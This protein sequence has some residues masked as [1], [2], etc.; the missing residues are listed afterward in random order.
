MQILI[1]G[2]VIIKM[3]MH[4]LKQGRRQQ[5][6]MTYKSCMASC[7]QVWI[8]TWVMMMQVL[9]FLLLFS[10]S[11]GTHR[12]KTWPL[13]TPHDPIFQCWAAPHSWSL[14]WKILWN[15][16]PPLDS[17]LR[18]PEEGSSPHTHNCAF[19]PDDNNSRKERKI[20]LFGLRCLFSFRKHR[21]E[22]IFLTI[23]TP[24]TGHMNSVGAVVCN[25]IASYVFLHPQRNILGIFYCSNLALQIFIT[26]SFCEC[27]ELGSI[28]VFT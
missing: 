13:H 26:F 17:R 4:I 22:N 23:L 12:W 7:I 10:C 28:I 24:K 19:H 1:T 5:H 14:W 27:N 15:L 25:M 2:L 16:V 3:Y 9:P 11:L 6:I 21:K 18:I 8:S 20:I